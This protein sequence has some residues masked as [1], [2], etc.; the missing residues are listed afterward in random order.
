MYRNHI[1]SLFKVS[2]NELKGVSEK[3]LIETEKRLGVKLPHKLVEFY[4]TFGENKQINQIFNRL[5]LP[6]ALEIQ[7]NYLIFYEEQQEVSYWAVKIDDFQEENPPVYVGYHLEGQT[8][9]QWEFFFPKLTDFLEYITFFNG[10]MGGLRY[11]ANILNENKVK[12][13]AVAWVEENRTEIKSLRIENQRYFTD[14]Y[15]EIIIICYN[16][17]KN[18]TGIFVGTQDQA[19]F[20][21]L[22]EL[23]GYDEWSYTSYDDEEDDDSWE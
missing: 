13:E 23:F 1:K 11:N 18:G 20:D 10:T 17:E 2:E 22:L 16:N 4:L 9:L 3:Y 8:D 7:N 15:E 12:K 21:N 5:I 19:H 14:N 6:E